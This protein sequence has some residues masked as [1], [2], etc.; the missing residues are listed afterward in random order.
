[1]ISQNKR[2]KKKHSPIAARTVPAYCT[3]ALPLPANMANPTMAT[4]WNPNKKTPRFL[5]RSASQL[6]VTVKKHAQTYGGTLISWALF[7]V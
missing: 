4:S 3:L 5:Y 1:M 6:A 7:A 2:K